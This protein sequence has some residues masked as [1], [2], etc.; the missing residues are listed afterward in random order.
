MPLPD[1]FIIIKLK[2]IVDDG[3]AGGGAVEGRAGLVPPSAAAAVMWVM[4]VGP[5]PSLLELREI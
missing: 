3:G 1:G 5:L 4:V 2:G